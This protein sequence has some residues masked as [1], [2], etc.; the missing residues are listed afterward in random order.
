MYKPESNSNR[1]NNLIKI[2]IVHLFFALVMIVNIIMVQK[3]LKKVHYT[4]IDMS[5]YMETINDSPYNLNHTITSYNCMTDYYLM[6][7]LK[8][9]ISCS[10]VNKIIPTANNKYYILEAKFKFQNVSNT[11]NCDGLSLAF[12][13][14]NKNLFQNN[15]LYNYNNI[16]FSDSSMHHKDHKFQFSYIDDTRTNYITMSY[17]VS[18]IHQPYYT[19][20]SVS[21]VTL[22]IVTCHNLSLLVIFWR[23]KK[24]HS[25][26]I[27][28]YDDTGIAMYN[29]P[30]LVYLAEIIFELFITSVYIA[31]YKLN[32]FE[33]SFNL[34]NLIVLLIQYVF[35]LLIICLKLCFAFYWPVSI[36]NNIEKQCRRVITLF[37]AMIIPSLLSL[38]FV[39]SLYFNFMN[40][41]VHDNEVVIL[42]VANIIVYVLKMYLLIVII[43]L[44]TA[45]SFLYNLVD[46][47]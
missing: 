23:Y 8:E 15:I 37:L 22:I 12:N 29:N 2:C 34:F 3:N 33:T 21:I 13:I 9:S 45:G 4:S 43:Y 19:L 11:N 17:I 25:Y 24:M 47:Y 36:F 14:D 7:I 42:V 31:Q 5:G 16:H 46:V 1:C 39:T 35:L 6:C 38:L 26:K 18:N 30:K 32:V 44:N 10:Y 27:T 20:F 40:Q 41:K 28:T